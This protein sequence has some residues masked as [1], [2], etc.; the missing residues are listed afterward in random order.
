MTTTLYVPA[1]H[2][3]HRVQEDGT[4]LFTTFA[5]TDKGK[6]I[7]RLDGTQ[8]VQI[9]EITL[10]QFL[11]AVVPIIALGA[12]DTITW[13]LPDETRKVSFTSKALKHALA[14]PESGD[15]SL[16]VV[17][18]GDLD[19]VSPQKLWNLACDQIGLLF[20][21][22]SDPYKLIGSL[23]IELLAARAVA[24]VG[25]VAALEA[26]RSRQHGVPAFLDDDEGDEGG[27]DPFLTLRPKKGKEYLN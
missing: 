20:N 19:K 4:N 8:N 24:T 13:L 9:L 27:S 21:V 11:H 3:L 6:L 2:G 16:V 5:S 18:E 17:P 10:A 14:A 26:A 23:S 12:L 22:D 7:D 25:A 1:T 15:T